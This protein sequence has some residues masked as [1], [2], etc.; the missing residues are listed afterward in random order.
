MKHFMH[1]LMQPGVYLFVLLISSPVL[2]QAQKVDTTK[3]Y[4]IKEVVVTGK[5]I[6]REI[7]PVQTLSGKELERLNSHS[8]ADALRYFSGIQLKDYGGIGGLKTVNVRSM[9]TNHTGVFYDGIQLGNAQNGQIDL[10]RFSLDNIEEISL[11]NGQKSA[12]FQPAKDFGSS[13]SIYIISK[14]PY[15]REGEKTHLRATFK[16]GSFGVVNP[17]FTWEEKLSKTLSNSLNTEWMHA[18]GRYKFRYKKKDSYDTTAIRKNADITY[19]RIEDGLNKQIHGGSW[20]TKFYLYSSERGLPG[21]IVRGKFLHEDRQWDKDLFIQSSLK[22]SIN[23]RYSFLL[24]AKYAYDYT[25]YLT[26]FKNDQST[27]YINNTYRQHEFYF[28]F[29]NQY[30]FFPFWSA[31]LS[32]D[33]QWNKLD[34]NLRNFAYP[35]RYTTLVAAATSLQ[36]DQFKMQASLLSTFVHEIVQVDSA[37]PDKKKF[38]PAVFFS[39]HP[40]S[41]KDFNF[42][43]FY[44]RIFRMPTFNDL[45][46]TFIGNTQLK[47]EYTTQYDLGMTYGKD[48]T[49][50]SLRRIELQIDGYYNQVSNKI[51]AMPTSN[52]FRWTMINLG[53]VEIRGIDA[54]L[55]SAWNLSSNITANA[56]LS[57]TYQK[58]QDFTDPTKDYYGDQI[59]YIPW[60]SGSAI[61]NGTYK[62]WDLNYSYIYTGKRYNES[63]NTIAN[64]TP[65]WYTSDLSLA[66]R[67]KWRTSHIRIT[68]EVNNLFNQSYEV[69]LSYPMPGRNY[70]FILNISI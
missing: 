33:L 53:Y 55:Q 64:Y 54:A 34:A 38:T 23:S 36:F 13:G 15:F 49:T 66:K 45:Y 69:V 70:K 59:P 19:W 2:L 62:S 30:S 1:Q 40:W 28:S 10:G 58:A 68:A 24:N 63:A 46:Y 4:K 47:P 67:F 9:G 29:A 17:S 35:I 22:K 8:V 57:Y 44:K 18:T 14:H 42:R 32:S 20:N 41:K 5:R 3:V 61:I 65:P 25:H 27:M 39:Y 52:F 51:V 50:S 11:Y 26:P 21:F 12:I 31:A 7:I 60:N 48:F 16:T 6:I 37:A 56:R 43:G